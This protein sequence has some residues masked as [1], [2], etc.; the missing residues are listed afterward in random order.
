F[1]LNIGATNKN[2]WLAFDVAS[3]AREIFHL[4]NHIIWAKSISIGDDTIGHFKPITSQRFLNNLYEDVF[5]FTKTGAVALDRRAIGVP[6][7]YKS[8]IKR[9]GHAH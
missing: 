6:F 9:F 7:K 5:H 2:P 8:N 4:Q 1:F 3:Q